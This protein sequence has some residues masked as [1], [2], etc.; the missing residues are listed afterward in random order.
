MTTPDSSTP[1]RPRGRPRRPDA[2]TA[3]ERVQAS[4][5]SRR[6]VTI[7]LPGDVA[8]ALDALARQHGDASRPACVARLIQEA[9]QVPV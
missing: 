3:Y 4:R 6:A 1:K 9:A 7:E 8:D 2:P 5:V